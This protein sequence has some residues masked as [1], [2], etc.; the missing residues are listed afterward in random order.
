[1]DKLAI[2][3]TL[4]MSDALHELLSAAAKDGSRPLNTEILRRLESTFSENLKNEFSENINDLG[5]KGWLT[6]AQREEV[7]R[8]IREA[9]GK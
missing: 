5:G 7:E 8:M 3:V 4:R 2:R 9:M 1:M 6:A